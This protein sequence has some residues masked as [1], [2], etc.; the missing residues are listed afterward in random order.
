MLAKQL[1]ASDVTIKSR[2]KKLTANGTLKGFAP[3][4]DYDKLGYA[5]TSFLELKIV[6]GTLKEVVERGT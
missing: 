6:P 4:I 5:V 3:I 2:V 1:D